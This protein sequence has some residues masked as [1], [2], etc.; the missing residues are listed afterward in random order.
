MYIVY[1]ELNGKEEVITICDNEQQAKHKL[2]DEF[3]KEQENF[4]YEWG[5]KEV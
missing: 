2:V 3:V 5:I 1:K 4:K